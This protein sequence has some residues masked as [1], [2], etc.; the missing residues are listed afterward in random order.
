VPPER[1]ESTRAVVD[2]IEGDL[3]VLLVGDDEREIHVA[4]AALPEGAEEGS[5]LRVRVD[6][7]EV[8]VVELDPDATR[9]QRD[10][11][12]GKLERLRT[13]RGG[14]RFRR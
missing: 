11:I 9:A 7:D 14:S 12:D 2:R 8:E 4:V 5:W 3:A 6:G 10:R 1:P 13:E